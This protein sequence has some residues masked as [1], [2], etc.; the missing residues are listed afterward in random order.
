MDTLARFNDAMAYVERNLMQEIDFKQLSRIAGCSEYHFGRMFSFLAAMPL[1]EYI[2]RRRLSQAGLLLQSGRVKVIDLALQL[3]YQS[4]EAFGRAFLAMHGITPSHAKK[5]NAAL[6]VLPPMTFQLT[7]KGGV[8]MDYRIVEKGAFTI[9]GFCKRITLQFSGANPQMDSLVQKLTPDRIAE[10]KGLCNTEPGGILSVS[11]NF[12]DRTREGS[13]LD[14]Y[15]GVAT[16]KNPPDG[17]DVLPVAAGVWAVFQAVGAFPD[18]VGETWAKIYAQWFPSSGYELTGGAELLW[19]GTP[20][21][22]S[23]D[24]KSEIWVPV[25]RAKS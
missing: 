5:Q 4:P 8:E 3:G 1:G 10:L 17:Y 15:I 13:E 22:D 12:A 14:Q 23:P 20:D 2:R 9:V 21:I 24:H 18:A 16:T 7:V 11:A 6:K 25:C 19:N